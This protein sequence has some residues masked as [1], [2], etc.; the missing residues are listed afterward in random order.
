LIKFLLEVE[1]IKFLTFGFLIE[2]LLVKLAMVGLLEVSKISKSTAA[3][4]LYFFC[5]D[6]PNVS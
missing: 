3:E 5:S 2:D 6:A 1:E 4:I